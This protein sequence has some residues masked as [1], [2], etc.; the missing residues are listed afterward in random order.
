MEP[1]IGKQRAI[2][3]KGHQLVVAGPGSGKTWLLIEKIK[4]LLAQGVP[5]HQILALTFSEKAA[6]EMQNRIDEEG[7]SHDL[8]I[9]TFHSFCYHFLEEEILD[10]GIS[11]AKGMISPEHQMV[12]G[13][14]HFD[15]F[16]I[17]A[18]E[19]RNNMVEVVEK[20]MTGISAF[21]DELVTPEELVTYIDT[22]IAEDI[23][24][25]E[26]DYLGKLRDLHSVYA[27]YQQYKLDH[28]FIDFDDMIHLTVDTLKKKPLVAQRYKGRYPFIM[29]D[30][31]QDTNFAQFELIRLIGNDNVFVVG[32]DDQ[33]IYRFRGAYL[34]NFEDFKR[35]YPDT[36]L[37]HLIENYRSSAHIVNLALDLMNKV[38]DREQKNLFTKN[39]DG[40]KI[41]E[42]ICDDEYAEAEFI[43]KTITSLHG[44]TYSTN[45]ESDPEKKVQTL[46]YKDF[47]VLCRKRYH[48]MKVYEMLRQHDIPCEFR[49][50]VDFFSEPI[51][52]DLLAWLRIIHNPLN[53]G[54]SLFRIMR[55]CGISEV[56]AIKVN[57]HARNYSDDDTRNDG[58]YE[59]MVNAEEFLPGDG[60]LV[61][62][63]THRIEEFTALKSRKVLTELVHAVM[64]Q[65]SGL[66]RL[67]LEDEGGDSL[68]YLNKFFEIAREYADA[69][70]EPTLSSLLDYLDILSDFPVSLEEVSTKDAVQILTI[71][72]SKGLEFPVVFIPDLVQTHFPMNFR[73]KQ[74]YV[75]NALVKSMK[76]EKSE[77][78]LFIE[79]ERRLCYVAMTRAENELY[80]LRPIRYRR[81]KKDSKPSQF[82]DE[83]K[84]QDHPLIDHVAISCEGSI[85]EQVADTPLDIVIRS[86]REECIRALTD[87]RITAATRHLC[88]LEQILLYRDGKDPM[89]ARLVQHLDLTG[90]DERVL[91]LM[92]PEKRS[93]IPDDFTLSPTSLHT[94]ESC[95]M[96]F[97]FQYVLRIPTTDKSFFQKGTAIH[98]VIEQ[99][100]AEMAEGKDPDADRLISMLHDCWK[101]EAFDFE[102]VAEQ[103]KVS[104]EESLRNFLDWKEKNQNRVVE[105]EKSFTYPL[106]LPNGKTWIVKGRIDRIEDEEGEAVVVDFKSG[107]SRI[108]KKDVPVD[109]QLNMYA[110][111]LQMMN[112]KLPKRASLVYL[113][114]EG[115]KQVDYFPT[116]QSIGVFR[117]KLD[118]MVQAIMEE[119]FDPT[120]GYMECRFCDYGGLC[121][122]KEKD[123]E[124]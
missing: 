74:F 6:R 68:S 67:A 40:K 49:G 80:L 48:G 99:A 100:T 55:L 103:S 110:M 89:T 44:T 25:E 92:N 93:L 82:L 88:T 101:P 37:Y 1:I 51:I 26:R 97:K 83:M 94:Y 90:P 108:A 43:L 10:S 109:V 66:Y 22:R 18:I 35:T 102:T 117:E 39:P 57:R 112:G 119:R 111:A 3:E 24:D 72:R 7:G 60:A 79:E 65:A 36:N 122:G 121:P 120:P 61:K 32:D 85:R 4:Y 96:R 41:T 52:L 86:V 114:E 29:I 30:E 87:G 45:K 77:K 106:D 56:S 8:T 64:T 76:S 95:P 47:A 13:I 12:W 42:A 73:E 58:V 69:T 71:H 84:W 16:N 104:A 17:Q 70:D 5:G 78:S 28:R 14:T 38:Q 31:F 62:E 50:D 23:T 33:T 20:I 116:E 34:T 107:K 124:S 113:E 75:P 9:R 81:N 19:V 11:F 123:P 63:I 53:A 2:E 46:E 98:K 91:S 15:D 105:T 27:A 118:G 54:P 59:A 115:V 21:R